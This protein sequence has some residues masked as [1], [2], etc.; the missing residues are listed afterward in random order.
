MKRILM[1]LT[2]C[3]GII[4]CADE[5]DNNSGAGGPIDSN[6]SIPAP[7]ADHTVVKPDT[8][9]IDSSQSKVPDTSMRKENGTSSGQSGASTNAN[10]SG[11]AKDDTKGSK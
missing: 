3:V 5:T 7:A 4:A 6:Y 2:V 1:F 10:N 11:S 9:V 8:V